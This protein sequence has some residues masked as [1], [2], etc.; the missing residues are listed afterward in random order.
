VNDC[1]ARRGFTLIELMVAVALIGILATVAYSISTAALRNARVDT[2]MDELVAQIGSLRADAL[3]DLSDRLLVLVDAPTSGGAGRLFVLRGPTAAWKLSTFDP[4]SPGTEVAAVEEDLRL[5]AALR[6]ANVTS[7]APAPLATVSFLDSAMMGTCGGPRCFALR[8]RSN[9]DVR[10]EKPAGGDAARPGF[11]FVVTSTLE[12][13][14]GSG[15]KR[16][17]IVVG[18]P[19]GVVRSYSP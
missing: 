18:F 10:G 6:I 16:R 12:T 5:N 11:G 14:G 3:T 2:A 4:A 7:R 17:A 15:Y 9:G 1:N 13:E 8:F 19:S